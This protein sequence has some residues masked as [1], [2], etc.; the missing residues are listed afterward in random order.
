MCFKLCINN[1]ASGAFEKC[2][3]AYENF[4]YSHNMYVGSAQ[5]KTKPEHVEKSKDDEDHLIFNRM[6]LLRI[7]RYVLVNI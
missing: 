5:T 2:A 7:I 1:K 6:V 4:R 3:S